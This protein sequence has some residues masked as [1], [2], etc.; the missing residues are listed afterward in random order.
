MFW[1]KKEEKKGLPDLSP[2]TKPSFVI[3][4]EGEDMDGAAGNRIDEDQHDDKQ[5]LPSF[6]DSLHEKGFSQAAIKDAVGDAGMQTVSLSDE[7]EKRFQSVEMEE[8]SPLMQQLSS[9]EEEHEVFPVVAPAASYMSMSKKLE[10]P[11][12]L[13]VASQVQS[14]D[15]SRSSKNSDIFVKLDKF[16]SARKS[17]HDA[18]NKLGELD[19][20]LKKIRETKLREEQE[21][22]GWEKELGSVKS[23]V[24]DIVVN[25]FEKVD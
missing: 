24:N 25:L 23:K 18:Q 4:Q 17:L 13:P 3:K 12:A 15:F 11:P 21:L 14:L 7:P 8:W 16:Y 2:Y 9:Q 5:D 19:E 20:L 6:P 1:G 22:G 10:E